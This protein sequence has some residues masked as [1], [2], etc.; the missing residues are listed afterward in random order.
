MLQ[1]IA[2]AAMAIFAG[3]QATKDEEENSS[4]EENENNNPAGSTS[5]AQIGKETVTDG[6][7]QT[8]V[9]S[10]RGDGCFVVSQIHG[11]GYTAEA[12]FTDPSGTQYDK[13]QI[14]GS[15][16]G[17]LGWGLQLADGRFAI[18]LQSLTNDTHG[19][20]V[21]DEDGNEVAY[22]DLAAQNLTGPGGVISGPDNTLFTVTNNGN[23]IS[24]G[25]DFARGSS[26]VQLDP[27]STAPSSYTVEEL[28]TTNAVG[29]AQTDH[30][31]VIASAGDYATPES[32]ELS[33]YGIGTNG[34]LTYD[35][36]VSSANGLGLNGILPVSG[37]NILITGYNENPVA[38]FDGENVTA[39]QIGDAL[40]GDWVAGAQFLYSNENETGIVLNSHDSNN[41]TM[42]VYSLRGDVEQNSWEVDSRF[43]FDA[44]SPASV[45]EYAP[46]K[47]CTATDSAVYYFAAE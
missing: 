24:G 13:F 47:Y 5:L 27:Y 18:P 3:C 19:V 21:I 25:V 12:Q 11:D 33:L 36:R 15:Q 22:H 16:R 44:N 14:Q 30:G 34:L 41:N 32:A 1:F 26:L 10:A 7:N 2:L 29:L 20:L 42:T 23:Y 39:L 17:T 35:R 45:V 28:G 40:Q 9:A 43:L 37:D 6:N 38:L 8:L 46:Q 4:T 31:L